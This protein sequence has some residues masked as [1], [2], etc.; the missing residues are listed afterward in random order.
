MAFDSALKD[1]GD[2]EAGRV[3]KAV[4]DGD[5]EGPSFIPPAVLSRFCPPELV[6]L[7]LSQRAGPREG[8]FLRS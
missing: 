4:R 1:L 3:F 5:D 7:F 6:V 2:W 8:H